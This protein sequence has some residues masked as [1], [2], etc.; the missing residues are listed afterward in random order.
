MYIIQSRNKV[1]IIFSIFLKRNENNISSAMYV[2]AMDFNLQRTL[3]MIP[4]RW[5]S[6]DVAANVLYC[7][8]RFTHLFLDT[9]FDH[10]PVPRARFTLSPSASSFRNSEKHERNSFNSSLLLH[11]FVKFKEVEIFMPLW[12][13]VYSSRNCELVSLL[14]L[15]ASLPLPPRPPRAQFL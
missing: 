13:T 3:S 9:S 1:S 4:D 8:I 15:C 5:K 6:D 14:S 11:D 2:S 12:R 10:V 7:F